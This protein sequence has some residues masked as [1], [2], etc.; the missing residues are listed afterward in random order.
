ML[1]GG[2]DTHRAW[3]I[4]A[5]GGPSLRPY[6]KR[7]L[8]GEGA[9]AEWRLPPPSLPLAARSSSPAP[10]YLGPSAALPIENPYCS[11]KGAAGAGA[12][13]VPARYRVLARVEGRGRLAAA[14]RLAVLKVGLR[15]HSVFS[16]QR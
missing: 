5:A 12:D 7:L 11:C 4:L 14:A 6:W 16:L 3:V 15:G 9:G 2:R 8:K 1:P 10:P 13:V